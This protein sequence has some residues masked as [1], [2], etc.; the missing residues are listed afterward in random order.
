VGSFNISEGLTLMREGRIRCLGYA[1][2]E[3]WAQAGDV[4]TF[5]DQGFDV[6]VGSSRGFVGPPGL[7]P[8]IQARL[9]EALTAT[10]ADPT[11]LAE[12][13]RLGLPL[14]P[15]LGEA[16]RAAVLREDAAMRELYK[17]RPWRN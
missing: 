9:V 4:P 13:E 12:A 10:L 3:R 1:A 7:P 15:R 11:F 6:M 8:A 5:R 17:R 16:Y 14:Q 2:P